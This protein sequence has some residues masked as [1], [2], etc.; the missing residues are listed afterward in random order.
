MGSPGS[1]DEMFLVTR[2]VLYKQMVR[3]KRQGKPDAWKS[4][5]NV[6]SRDQVPTG[7]AQTGKLVY[8]P[9]QPLAHVT[10]RL[11]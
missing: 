2:D 11:L 4:T 9:Q 3:L 8:L 7:S 1:R 10:F 6:G 5:V